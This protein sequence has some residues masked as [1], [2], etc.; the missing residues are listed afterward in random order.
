MQAEPL[1]AQTPSRSSA[2]SRVSE[3]KPGKLTLSVFASR[4]A[5]R[6]VLLRLGQAALNPLPQLIAQLSFSFLFVR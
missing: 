2:M 1:E 5:R 3:E 4:G 6:G